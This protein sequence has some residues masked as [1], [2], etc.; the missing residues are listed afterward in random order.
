MAK[1]RESAQGIREKVARCFNDA[2]CYYNGNDKANAKGQS[3]L[4]TVLLLLF[5]FQ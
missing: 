4:F 3:M 5:L 2:G 1:I